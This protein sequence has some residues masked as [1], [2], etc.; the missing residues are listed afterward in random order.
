MISD[1]YRSTATSGCSYCLLG[2]APCYPKKEQDAAP[3]TTILMIR[4]LTTMGCSNSEEVMNEGIRHH[5]V[6]VFSFFCE[7]IYIWIYVSEQQSTQG[8]GG[9][10]YV[11]NKRNERRGRKREREIE[12]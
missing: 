3:D 12:Q 11:Y 8:K 7:T 9:D 6:G 5:S 2:H 4:L 1:L 10:I